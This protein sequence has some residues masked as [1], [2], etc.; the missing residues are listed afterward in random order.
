MPPASKDSRY[1]ILDLIRICAALWV[2]VYHLSGGHGWFSTQKYPY[3]NLLDQGELG[4]FTAFVR[5]GFIGVPIFFV[6]SG[7]VIVKSSKGKSAQDF[8][9]SRFSRLFPAFLFSMFVTIAFS[10][11][12]YASPNKVDMTKSLSTV[13]L[14]WSS[15]GSSPIQGSYWTLWPELRFYG[16]FL[17]SVLLTMKTINYERKVIYFFISWLCTFWF[18]GKEQPFL[19]SVLISDY[20]IYFV[21]GGLLAL[22]GNQKKL[23]G[24]FPNMEWNTLNRA[25]WI[26][27]WNLQK[28]NIVG[29]CELW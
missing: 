15:S 19:S 29:F 27:I 11:Y 12:G 24:L 25:L 23:F 2:A 21:L 7:F 28:H 4:I 13:G 5:L 10:K 22:A 17:I 6:I 20:G 1:W 18:V 14:F 3:E 26:F 9:I 8:F 16:L